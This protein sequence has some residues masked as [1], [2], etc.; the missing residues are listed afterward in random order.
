MENDVDFNALINL[1]GQSYFCPNTFCPV[2][3]S[4]FNVL[5]NFYPST[6]SWLIME[7]QWTESES[8]PPCT[9]TRTPPGLWPRFTTWTTGRPRTRRSTME[10]MRRTTSCPAAWVALSTTHL[11]ETR[12]KSTGVDI[13]VIIIT[14]IVPSSLLWANRNNSK[15]N[16]VGY[17]LTDKNTNFHVAVWLKARMTFYIKYLFFNLATNPH[18]GIK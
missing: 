12:T 18:H 2:T 15:W 4:C 10:P 5:F 7:A 11:R 16:V 13:V 8:P 14:I 17:F 9:E 6:M 3:C 1:D